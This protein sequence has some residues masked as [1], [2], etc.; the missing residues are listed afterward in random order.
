MKRTSQ[1]YETFYRPF[2]SDGGRAVLETTLVL[3]LISFLLFFA[4]ERYVISI[5]TVKETALTVELSNLR[6]AV[7]YFVLAKKRLP[8]SLKE[9]IGEEAVLAGHAIEGKEYNIVIASRYV[10]TM[11]RDEDGYPTDPFGKRFAYDQVTGMVRSSTEGY[12]TW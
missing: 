11:K 2:H 4:I 7:N 12:E 10:E 1:P 3:I 5:R 8:R 9:L 6:V